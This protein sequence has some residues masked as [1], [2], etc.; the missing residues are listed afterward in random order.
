MNPAELKKAMDNHNWEGLAKAFQESDVKWHAQEWQDFVTTIKLQERKHCA[1][2]IRGWHIK[3]REFKHWL[4]ELDEQELCN[5]REQIVK[6]VAKVEADVEAEAEQFYMD[7][8][9]KAVNQALKRAAKELE[10]MKKKN[11]NFVS[12][13]VNEELVE[14][15]KTDGYNQA[16]SEAA[17][18][19][20]ELKK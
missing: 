4:F 19:I 16:L 8:M 9:D 2:I 10:G 13:A 20:R 15:C 3:R 17:K 18:A 7:K 5:A 1:E 11:D 6:H 14:Y 12:A